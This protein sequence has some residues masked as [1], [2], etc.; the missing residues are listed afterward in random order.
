MNKR[1]SMFVYKHDGFFDLP[2]WAFLA[3]TEYLGLRLKMRQ[4]L[5]FDVNLRVGLLWEQS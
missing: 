4:G 2:P 1:F 5:N 3:Y